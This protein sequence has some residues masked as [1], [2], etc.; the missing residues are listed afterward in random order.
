MHSFNT[1]G[2]NTVQ[3]ELYNICIA[4]ETKWNR[5]THTMSQYEIN[6][7]PQ[8]LDLRLIRLMG[9]TGSPTIKE[10]K[11]PTNTALSQG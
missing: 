2:P 9:N 8:G 10:I 11:V 1:K 5:F 4:Q 3:H 6:T 7:S